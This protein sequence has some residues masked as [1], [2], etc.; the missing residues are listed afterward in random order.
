MFKALF[1]NI[2]PK[3]FYYFSSKIIPWAFVTSIVFIGYGLYLGLFV[4]PSDYQ[5]GDAFRIIYVHVPSAWLS[6]F[7]YS[8]VFICSIISLIWKIKVFESTSGDK[9]SALMHWERKILIFLHK[10]VHFWK[11]KI[12]SRKHGGA[13]S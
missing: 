1:E 13:K 5:Q 8:A 12:G 10:I 2:S 7:A 3:N 4:A 11:Q 6:L 9:Q